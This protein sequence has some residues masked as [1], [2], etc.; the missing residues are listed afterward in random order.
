M[1]YLGVSKFLN[2]GNLTFYLSSQELPK[3]NCYTYLDVPFSNDL[4][5]KPIIE[6]MNNRIIEVRKEFYSLKGFLKNPYIPIPYKRMLFYAIVI[7]QVWY[8]TPL[9]ESNIER[10]RAT[11]IN[12]GLYWIEGFSLLGF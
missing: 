11:Q 9:L 12:T 4:E 3:T 6:R 8:Y 10:T 5:L 1:L 2:N 7:E